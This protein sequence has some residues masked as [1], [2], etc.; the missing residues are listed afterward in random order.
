MTTTLPD[1]ALS[2]HVRTFIGLIYLE[3][4]FTLRKTPYDLA[5]YTNKIFTSLAT[6][7]KLSFRKVDIKA[8]KISDDVQKCIELYRN[9]NLNH[10]KLDYLNGWSIKSKEGQSQQVNLDSIYCQYGTEF[11]KTILNALQCFGLK[12]N[13]RH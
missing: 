8:D 7:L 3:T 1:R 9:L 4:D 12:K 11:T 10:E 6:T 2:R 5:K 13:H